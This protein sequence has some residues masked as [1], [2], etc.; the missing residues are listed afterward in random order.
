MQSARSEPITVL[1]ADPSDL[2]GA[3]LR[4]ILTR[5]PLFRLVG[6]TLAELA[7]VAQELGPGLI[8]TAA[9]VVARAQRL[10]PAVIV[11]DPAQGGRLDLGMIADLRRAAPASRLVILTS[12][13]E[14][15]SF[16]AALLQGTTAYLLK[17]SD[18]TAR[19]VAWALEGVARDGALVIDPGIA[20]RVLS[21]PGTLVVAQPPSSG[22][23]RLT[24]RE[25]EVLLLALQGR[26]DEEIARE[27]QIARV[28]AET[29][30]RNIMVKLA[31]T[32]RTQLG[33]IAAWQRLLRASH[34]PY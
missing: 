31:A 12:V 32:T 6:E 30:I 11:F 34:S 17:G 25:R 2:T 29:H 22:V 7:S 24:R 3:G 20:E 16:A 9:G 8:G 5:N 23:Q 1:L 4:G 15:R 18:T 26:T 13:F 14:P 28:T 19:F 10:Q 27:L 21:D 33:C